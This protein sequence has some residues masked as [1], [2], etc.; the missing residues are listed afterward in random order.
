MFRLIAL[1]L[2]NAEIARELHLT[3]G[4]VKTHV[5]RVLQKLSLRDRV[6]AVVLAYRTRLFDTDPGARGLGTPG[7][8]FTASR[9]QGPRVVPRDQAPWSPGGP[10]RL[11]WTLGCALMTGRLD[12]ATMDSCS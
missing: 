11:G 7:A 3:E 1:G 10:V 5:T 2:S 6:Q 9:H 4:T 8:A 12:G